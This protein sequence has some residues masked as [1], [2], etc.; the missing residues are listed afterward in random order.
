MPTLSSLLSP[1]SVPASSFPPLPPPTSSSLLSPTSTSSHSIPLSSTLL[2]SPAT[3]PT[4]QSSPLSATQD[5]HLSS[6]R[7]S[8]RLRTWLSLHMLWLSALARVLFTSSRQRPQH[9][10]SR[11]P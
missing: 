9:R 8:R 3:S 5:G 6:Q 11:L 4:T 2:S 7:P 1:L 10:M